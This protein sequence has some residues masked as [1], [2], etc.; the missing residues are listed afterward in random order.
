MINNLY[1]FIALSQKAETLPNAPGIFGGWFTNSMVVTIIV[2]SILLISTKIATKNMRRIP[3]GFQNFFEALIEGMYVTV[4]DV[5]GKKLAPKCFP[6]LA[7]IFLFYLASNWFGLMPGVGTIG[8]A[9]EENYQG[10]LMLKHVDTPLFRPP[11]TDL[12][13]NLAI[14]LLFMIYWL[15]ISIKEVGFIGFIKHL[16]APKGKFRGFMLAGMALIFIFVGLLEVV[17]IVIRPISLSLRIYGNV[18]AGENLMHQMAEIGNAMGLG[19]V[20]S[21]ILRIIV[22]IPFY[23]LELL[24][25]F[26]QSVVFVMLCAV[27]IKLSTEHDDEH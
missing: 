6:I 23:F 14:A 27:Y 13:N 19:E 26:I 15:Y 9:S 1:Y 24:V 7:T 10:M 20:F 16:F 4:E 21:Y 5:V 12:N 3:T 25:G 8:W 2:A 22:P 11:A 18:F 17:S